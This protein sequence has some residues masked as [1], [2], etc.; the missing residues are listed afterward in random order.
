M[1]L[2]GL[3]VSTFLGVLGTTITPYLFFWQ[4][5]LEVEDRTARRPQEV[6]RHEE[7]TQ[8]EIADA[9]ADVNAGMTYSNVIM[10]FIIVTTA[11]TLGAQHITIV[12]AQDAA[13]ALRPLAGP[14]AELLFALGMVGA[15][16]LAVPVLAGSSAYAVAETFSQPEG[17]SLKPRKAVVFY[18]MI[19]AGVAIGLVIQLLGIDPIRALFW[20]AVING[21]VAVPL[22]AA[23][24][25]LANDRRLMGRWTNSRAANAWAIL[26]IALM[27]A[28]AVGLFVFWDS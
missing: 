6:I 5:S 28:A 7:P 23:I 8:R 26:T 10:F 19:A 27:S 9:H 17:L 2:T 20:S 21:L 25:V 18:S 13:V 16:L 14:F 12:T 3:W 24:T 22:I 11:A 1:H 4:T 15:G